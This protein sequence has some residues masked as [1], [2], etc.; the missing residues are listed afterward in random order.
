MVGRSESPWGT[1]EHL[2]FTL[3]ETGQYQLRVMW[4]D[5]NYQTASTPDLLTEY[6]LAWSVSA[7]PEPSLATIFSVSLMIFFMKRKRRSGCP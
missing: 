4:E 1:S 7:I 6:G 2:R 5:Q 3:A